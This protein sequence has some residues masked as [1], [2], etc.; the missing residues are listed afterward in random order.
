VTV[1][2]IGRDLI[3]GSRI[4][5]SAAR[6]DREFLRVE[7]PARLPT[8]SSV[9]LVLV[10]WAERG[11]DWGER[12]ATWRESEPTQRRPRIVLYGPHSDLAAHEAARSSGL[13]PMLARS[14][15]LRR[16][17]ELSGHVVAEKQR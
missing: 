10:D 8:P 17:V 15:L 13:G 3:F 6:A 4:A 2:L 16:V 5:D 12:L 7:E 1:V 9:E 14:V 11:A